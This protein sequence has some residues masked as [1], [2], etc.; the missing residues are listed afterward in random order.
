V[1]RLLGFVM[2]EAAVVAIGVAL[3]FIAY[4]IVIPRYFGG[5]ATPSALIV[6][7]GLV[8][9]G[10]G[11]VAKRHFPKRSWQSRLGTVAVSV[12]ATAATFVAALF[13]IL[14]TRGA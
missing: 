2:A 4:V 3:L 10:S 7:L 6:G 11:Y 12:M 5:V 9:I 8:A 1:R 13:F 14:N